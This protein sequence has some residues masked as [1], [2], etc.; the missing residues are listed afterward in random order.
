MIFD[1]N[2]RLNELIFV[3]I[4]G[5]RHAKNNYKIGKRDKILTDD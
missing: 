5:G 2:S 4:F 3:L 1:Q